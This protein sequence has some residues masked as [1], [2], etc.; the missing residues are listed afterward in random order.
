MA[1]QAKGKR[2]GGRGGGGGRGQGRGK[3]TGNQKKNNQG[4]TAQQPGTKF[5]TISS[6]T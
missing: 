4:A 1:K 6:I 5:S 3:S 2:G